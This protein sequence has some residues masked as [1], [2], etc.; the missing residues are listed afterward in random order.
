MIEKEFKN[1]RSHFD[2]MSG[3]SIL[4]YDDLLYYYVNLKHILNSKKNS[5]GIYLPRPEY[6][7]LYPSIEYKIDNPGESILKSPII[8]PSNSNPFIDSLNITIEANNR[9]DS[10]NHFN[11]QIL[12]SVN[13]GKFIEYK[14][15]FFITDNST[16]VAYSTYSQ[17]NESYKSNLSTAHF[18]KRPHN[19]SIQLNCKYN[20]QYTA[21]G[22]DGIIDG[23]YA[24]KD[25]RKGGWQGYQYQDFEAIIDMKE[26]KEFAEISANFLQDTRSWILFPT[27]VEFYTSDDNINYKLVQTDSNYIP[28]N[29][30]NVQTQK[31]VSFYEDRSIK[32]LPPT[33]KRQVFRSARYIKVKAYNYGKL[34]EWHAGKGDDAFIFIDE[35]EVK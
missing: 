19:Y 24:D 23:Q 12:Y 21:D 6:N 1:I 7:S 15:P 26:V 28:A 14:I 5:F 32:I 22:D 2:W 31:F 9:F 20:K 10:S 4:P 13:N 27:K 18:Y 8:V 34:P 35:I 33:Q 30:Y 3:F 17:G 11:K 25:F 16:V 29:D